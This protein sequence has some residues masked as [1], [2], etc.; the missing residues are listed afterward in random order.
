MP[1]DIDSPFTPGR[2]VPVD[3]FVGRSDEIKHLMA[4]AAGAARGKFQAAF[5]SGERGIGKSSLASFVRLLAE[6]DHNMLGLHIFLGG[7]TT[8]E[9][10]VRRVFD[11]LIKESIEKPWYKKVS[12]FLG[13]HVRKVGLFGISFEFGASRDELKRTVHD[14]APAMRNLM[15]QLGE[16]KTGII[17]ILDDINGLASLPAFANWLKSLVDEIATSQKSL[18]LYL[19]LVG[20]EERRRSL[21]QA[22][23]SSARLFDVVEIRAWSTED[24]RAFFKQA[25][26]TVGMTVDKNAL[27]PL[28]RYAGG[29]PVLAHELGDA[30]FRASENSTISLEDAVSGVVAAADIIGRKYLR[31]QV[32][33]EI[34][35]ERYRRILQKLVAGQ[36]GA[37]FKR[38]EVLALLSKDEEKVVD[39][40]LKKMVRLDVFV[41]DSSGRGRGAYRFRHLL[42]HLYFVLEAARERA[43]KA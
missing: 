23:P 28:A 34:R 42:H 15:R 21:V 26:N 41:R 6:K 27:D 3:L 39:S 18:S 11:R 16:E 36:L 14:F 12:D 31:P 43:K 22:Q 10:M 13:D 33:E 8:L 32:L 19:L 30:A 29:L 7:V 40:F 5:I 9:E 20:T 24:T 17:L 38:K 25:F 35:S 4:R 37:E 2:P 1:K